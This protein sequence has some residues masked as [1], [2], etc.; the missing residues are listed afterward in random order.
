MSGLRQ[1]AT[2]LLVCAC[3]AIGSSAYAQEDGCV[4]LSDGWSWDGVYNGQYWEQSLHAALTLVDTTWAVRV[5]MHYDEPWTQ[6]N[7]C[8][9]SVS[10]P[11][12]A[13]GGIVGLSAWGSNVAQIAV[14]Y[15]DGKTYTTKGWALCEGSV[16]DCAPPVGWELTHDWHLSGDCLPGAS[17]VRDTPHVSPDLSARP[18]SSPNPFGRST[19]V[20]FELQSATR[21]S[22]AIY[23]LAGRQV[24]ALVDAELIPGSHALLWDGQDDHGRPVSGGIYLAR[25]TA[26]GHTL[27]TTLVRVR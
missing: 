14:T 9:W 5:E 6:C 2:V 21:V 24:R 22:A 18:R 15:S 7:A 23:D 4:L 19:L 27:S 26:L 20:T 12:P 13:Q 11:L 17:F 3:L 25:V 10:L 8:S 16:L 1:V